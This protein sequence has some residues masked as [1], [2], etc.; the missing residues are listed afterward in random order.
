MLKKVAL[1]AAIGGMAVFAV[2]CAKRTASHVSKRRSGSKY[3]QQNR[4]TPGRPPFG[5]GRGPRGSS[6][7]L[8]VGA[9]ICTAGT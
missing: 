2:G 3:L 9:G 5:D 8:M 4:E 6:S 7:V 1:S